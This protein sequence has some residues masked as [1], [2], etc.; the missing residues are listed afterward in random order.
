MSPAF[1]NAHS[2]QSSVASHFLPDTGEQE[3]LEAPWDVVRWTRL[4]KINGQAFSELGKR[5]FGRPTCIAVSASIV[6]GTSKGT[7]LVFDYSQNLRAIIGPGSKA[8][9]SGAVTSIS[10]SADHSTVAAGHA[11]GNIFTWD[12]TKPAK[13]FL[14]I[15][16]VDRK[17]TPEVDGHTLDVAILHM[18]FLGTRRTALA[19][20]D[21]KGM[22]FSHLAS[23]G[24]GVITRS[25]STTRILGR[26]PDATPHAIRQRRPSSVLAFSP[27]PLGNAE[28]T[29]DSMGLVAMLT[30]YLLVIVST[31]PIAQTQYKTARPKE[32]AAHGAMS[33]SL[34]WFPSV[35]LKRPPGSPE[36]SSRVKLV[37]CWQNFLTIL[38]AIEVEPSTSSNKD[39]PPSLQF[40]PRSRWKAEESIVGTQ[41]LSR[42]VLAALT[43]TQQ[44]IILEDT[45][46]QITDSLDLIQK[47][48]YHVD[49]F[50]QQLNQLVDQL[51]EEDASMHG[52]VADAFYM[53]FR[54]YKGRLFLLGFSEVS[55][56]TL[57]N[58][59]DRLLA[60]VEEGNFIGAIQLATSYYEGDTEKVTVGLPED[61]DTRHTL[62]NAK[63]VEMMSASLKYTFSQDEE[64]KSDGESRQLQLKELAEACTSACVEI[65][66]LDFLFEDAYAW[67]QEADAEGVFLDV[68]EPHIMSG[69]I[70]T[71]PPIAI[72]DMISHYTEK[73]LNTRLEDLICHLDP[74]TMDIDQIT[75]LCK[76]NSLYDALLYV[77]NQALGD[78]T[79]IMKELLNYVNLPNGNANGT[80]TQGARQRMT[81]AS[82]IFPYMSYILTSRRYPMGSEMSDD[83]ALPAK[84]EIYS[85]LFSGGKN[86]N[87]PAVELQNAKSR[88]SFPNLRQVLDF[89]APSFLSML[90]EAFEDSF[91]NG[92]H[93]A[94]VAGSG[95][96]MTEE[97]LFG[98]T[99]NRQWIVSILLEVM[100][101]PSYEA[102]D[103][104]YLDMFISRN[105]PKFPQ[106][107]LLSGHLLHKILIDLCQ[108]PS[109]EVLD[110]CQLSVEY[111]LSIY[112]PPDLLSLIPLIAKARFYRVLKSIYKSEKQYPRLLET[113]F[114]EKDNPDAIFECIGDCLRPSSGLSEKQIDEVWQVIRDHAPEIVAADAVQAANTIEEYAPDLHPV[115]VEALAYDEYSQFRYLQT[116]LEPSSESSD[117]D[118]RELKL[119][120]R[121]FVEIYVR[122]LCDYDPHHVSDYI[123]RLRT[124][125]LRLDEVLPALEQSGVVDAAVVL[126]AREGKVSQGLNRLTVH[127]RTLEAALLG[128]VDGLSDTPDIQN[129]SEAAH[130]L[131]SSIRKYARVG[132]WL[133][134]GQSKAAQQSRTAA[135]NG[136]RTRA[137]AEVLSPDESLWLELIDAVVGVKKNAT[138]VLLS[139]DLG[140]HST[141]FDPSKLTA[142]LRTVV[143]DTFTALLGTTTAPQKD[144]AH[145]TDASFLRIFKAFLSRASE[146][147]PSLSNLR[148]VLGAIF[149]AYTYEESLLSL[150]NK[151]LDK[152]LFVH[153]READKLRRQGWRP[154]GQV[155]E[156]CGQKVWGPGTGASVWDAWQRKQ[157]DGSRERLRDQTWSDSQ[158]GAR[159][160]TANGKGK[161]TAMN[162]DHV[163]SSKTERKGKATTQP[164]GTKDEFVGDEPFESGALVVFAC[165][166]IFHRNCLQKMRGDAAKDHATAP[167]TIDSEFWCPLET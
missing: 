133:C 142:D 116:V 162:D 4:R 86:Q 41:W 24:M 163:S 56:G 8:A 64:A 68:L 156:G 72:K 76:R 84:A 87:Q 47:H 62:V 167:H 153:V 21:D 35:K 122:L 159:P 10:V 95:H 90:N 12:V 73:G 32:I 141:L 1:L 16:P 107:I 42:S 14:H 130:D 148:A 49:L 127:L 31:T 25:V 115:L 59:A 11:S 108:Y 55:F 80:E 102:E 5:N 15:P 77:W 89:D 149:S 22:A 51:D 88:S 60:L 75:T 23:K 101:P 111:L 58:W 66:D 152:D 139:L 103:T 145:R 61:D 150:S 53:S 140:E 38:E 109:E 50:S 138:Q 160:M 63:L 110:E 155:C 20:A 40:R 158:A 157:E 143:Q 45:S 117:N 136:K 113:C 71:L 52:V 70:E 94:P 128:L 69:D 37:Y 7:V 166:H 164:E 6:L 46:L 44:L 112:Q 9:E 98:L 118:H 27:L 57:S 96:S 3:T 33:A 74:R 83:Q 126:M 54:A 154:L 26:Y 79:T 123:E 39:D 19:S 114:E 147:S 131:V 124:G 104:I 34:A 97:Q 43:I 106:F 151:L 65:D 135:G 125:D 92:S 132:V 81:D 161:A 100:T 120:D 144:A 85:F 29:A 119:S 121:W 146:S 93:E 48:I 2:R 99:V 137:Q 129:T 30:P 165:R 13:P 105:L 67:Y 28:H 91:L 17:R 78:Y 36:A 82:K 134:Q 18:G